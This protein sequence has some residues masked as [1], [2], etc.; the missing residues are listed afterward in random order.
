M[1][2]VE[3]EE[4]EEEEEGEKMDSMC[5]IIPSGSLEKLKDFKQCTLS[6]GV[7]FLQGFF[8]IICRSERTFKLILPLFLS[9]LAI[10]V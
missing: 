2:E 7:L 3:V 1:E 8:F 10:L 5:T 9:L 6:L 4:E